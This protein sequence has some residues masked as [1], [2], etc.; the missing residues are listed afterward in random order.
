MPGAMLVSKISLSRPTT[1]P[2]P[3]FII[4]R[5]STPPLRP[6]VLG[7]WLTTAEPYVITGYCFAFQSFELSLGLTSCF[8]WRGLTATA[9]PG[10]AQ[11]HQIETAP[12]RL[13]LGLRPSL[14][15][16]ALDQRTT[17]QLRLTQVKDSCHPSGKPQAPEVAYMLLVIWS[18]LILL[19]YP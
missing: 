15:P 13:S 4:P 11:V 5:L 8:A 9:P 1:S 16:R 2:P 3:V 19:K 12:R 17:G 7:D 18:R 10:I 14:T 6:G